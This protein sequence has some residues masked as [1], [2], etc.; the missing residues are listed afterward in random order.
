MDLKSFLDENV[1]PAAGCTEPVAIGYAVSL[2]YNSIFGNLPDDPCKDVPMPDRDS[3][4]EVRLKVGKGVYKNAFSMAVPGTDGRK[5]IEIAASVGIY[6]D[7]KK[8]LELFEDVDEDILTGAIDIVNQ[9]KI[10]ITDVKDKAEFDISVD[11][12]YDVNSDR[13]TSSVRLEKFHDHI[14][15]IIVDGEVLYRDEDIQ[16]K[17]GSINVPDCIE[18]MVHA[19]ENID[20]ELIDRLYSGIEMNMAR[21]QDGL[22]NEYGIG[23]GRMLNEMIESGELSDDLINKVKMTTAAAADARMGGIEKPVMS[24]SGSGN[25]GI[26]VLVPIGVVG[27]E[28]DISKR[29]MAK[30]AMLAHQITKFSTERSSYLSALCGCSVKAGMGVTAGITYILG[31]STEQIRNSINLLAGNVTG[32]ICDG[33]KEGCALKI[34]TAAGE[35]LESSLMALKGLDVPDDNGIVGDTAE[36]TLENIGKISDEMATIDLKII[37]ILERKR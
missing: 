4:K 17:R 28:M 2:A 13:R 6:L 1:K 10:K 8:E 37:D 15:S 27:K 5:G 26:T 33:A 11:L 23:V 36:E 35:A 3:L 20:E 32:M 12:I 18:E 7:P 22:E 30:G 21:S 24:T 16:K 29:K 34:S 9:D 31:G 14:S 25:Q 19:A